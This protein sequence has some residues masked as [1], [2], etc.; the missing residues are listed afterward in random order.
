MTTSLERRRILTWIGAGALAP[1]AA[2]PALADDLKPTPR[3][4]EGPFYPRSFPK[5]VDADLT[6]MEGRASPAEG[7]PLDVTGRV[8]LRGQTRK[9]A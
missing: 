3:M 8:L 9:G 7:T 5:D 6:R 1:L 2:T 4:T